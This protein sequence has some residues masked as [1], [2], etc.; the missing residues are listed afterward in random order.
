MINASGSHSF[1]FAAAAEFR[2]SETRGDCCRS[3]YQLLGRAQSADFRF[4]RDIARL[5]AIHP[6]DDFI[7]ATGRAFIEFQ[8][9]LNSRELS[10]GAKLP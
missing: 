3:E 8:A 6:G 5:I 7:K 4:P 10:A 2:F 1:R 9:T